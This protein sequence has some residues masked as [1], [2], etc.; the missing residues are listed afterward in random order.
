LCACQIVQLP[1]DFFRPTAPAY[2]IAQIKCAEAEEP[3]Q[4]ALAP[5]IAAA[6]K[7]KHS[8]QESFDQ[9]CKNQAEKTLQ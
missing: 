3:G 4:Q 2:G 7:A 8:T 1:D 9:N 6:V 5:V